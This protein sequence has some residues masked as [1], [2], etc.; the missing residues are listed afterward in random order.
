VTLILGVAI[1]LHAFVYR[2]L[3][4]INAEYAET[5]YILAVNNKANS[6]RYGAN[7]MTTIEPYSK[8]RPVTYWPF[9]I[10]ALCVTVIILLLLY[11][12]GHANAGWIKSIDAPCNS[13]V[14][15]A[16]RCIVL[17]FV[18][19]YP[20][21]LKTYTYREAPTSVSRS[22]TTTTIT[23]DFVISTR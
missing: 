14:R 15:G 10:I 22:K 6:G 21:D 20:S 16:E 5:A 17:P 11:S 7:E 8:P 1:F 13:R 19:T 4:Y 3:I 18:Q 2:Q 12:A 23:T 9:K